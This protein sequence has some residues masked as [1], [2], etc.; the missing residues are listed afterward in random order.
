M[1]FRRRSWS[2]GAGLVKDTPFRLFRRVA[3]FVRLHENAA[4]CFSYRKT[5]QSRFRELLIAAIVE[6]PGAPAFRPMLHWARD[7][8]P[9]LHG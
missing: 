3:F 6:F 9:G 1:Q 2:L 5:R 7:Q 4:T 8:S